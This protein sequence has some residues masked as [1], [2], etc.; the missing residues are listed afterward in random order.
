VPQ[1]LSPR[2]ARDYAYELKR[3]TA[4]ARHHG[5][6]HLPAP[7]EAVVDYLEAT[8]EGRD[9]GAGRP[10][11]PASASRLG[12]I[13]S[14]INHAHEA[15]G[16]DGPAGHPLVVRAIERILTQR[17]GAGPPE[18]RRDVTRALG[19]A[20]S[21][22]L[23][24]M[25]SRL[26]DTP[27]GHRDAALLLIGA[28]V[29]LTPSELLALR[30]KDVRVGDGAVRVA[31]PEGGG[32]VLVRG[33]GPLDPVGALS[34][35]LRE[36]ELLVELRARRSGRKR[37]PALKDGPLFPGLDRHYNVGRHPLSLTALTMILRR[38]AEAAGLPEPEGLT[39]SSLRWLASEG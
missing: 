27:V 25:V 17:E 15:D 30:V 23:R 9:E 24:L 11:R 4:W 26:P 8:A 20:A 10:L 13:R 12:R 31:L 18:P 33:E 19:E 38:A 29:R 28:G 14:A 21:E 35:W 39:A 1:P 32:A 37:G 2:T 7:P 34:R 3:F 16:L 5:H 6:A 22:P 36:L